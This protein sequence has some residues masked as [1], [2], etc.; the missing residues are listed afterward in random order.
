MRDILKSIAYRRAR[1]DTR[2]EE[3]MS[4]LLVSIQSDA[5]LAEVAEIMIKKKIHRSNRMRNMSE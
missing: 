2:V 5:I 3:I 1:P 4:K